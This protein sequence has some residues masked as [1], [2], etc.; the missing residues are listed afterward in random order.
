MDWESEGYIVSVRKHGE[1]SAIIDVLTPDQ[2]RHA[3]L[4]RG[5]NSRRQRPA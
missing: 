1:S 2:G 3:G 5:G 4:V